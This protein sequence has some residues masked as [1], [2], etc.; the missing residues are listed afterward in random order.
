M[1]STR[2][3]TASVDVVDAK[4]AVDLATAQT[5]KEN[6]FLFVPNLIGSPSEA[7][8]SCVKPSEIFAR[9]HSRYPGS[10]IAS[11]YE[12]SPKVL[13]DS[14]LRFVFARRFRRLCC[15]FAE[16]DLKIRCCTGHGHR[17]V[18]YQS[19]QNL[20]NAEFDNWLAVQ[21]HVYCAICPRCIRHSH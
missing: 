14:V 16:A 19:S 17:S 6:V 4:V 11:F 3:R 8:P 18:C 1:S 9:L 10:R 15:A 20:D 21:R 5:Y 13:H 12:L 7:I 2:R